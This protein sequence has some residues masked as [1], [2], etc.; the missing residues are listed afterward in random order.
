MQQCVIYD[1]TELAGRRHAPEHP[2]YERMLMTF[3]CTI[4]LKFLKTRCL[5]HLAPP[6]PPCQVAQ[7]SGF[8]SNF[9]GRL[10]ARSTFATNI[11][12][13]TFNPC[14]NCAKQIES[15]ELGCRKI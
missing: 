7:I 6:R 4:S 14:L 10:S 15:N 1:T 9:A 8:Q 12:A 2:G 5:R 13:E 11:W 3:L